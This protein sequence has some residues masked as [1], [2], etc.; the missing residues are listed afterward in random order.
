MVHA[1]QF[2]ALGQW[3]V[4]VHGKGI[5]PHVRAQVNQIIGV[6]INDIGKTFGNIRKTICEGGIEYPPVKD[7]GI[8]R[9]GE[10]AID[11]VVLRLKQFRLSLDFR[12][13]LK[14]TIRVFLLDQG[15]RIRL[16]HRKVLIFFF[17]LRYANFLLVIERL[18]LY[19]RN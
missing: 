14:E 18:L 9:L 16:K 3:V 5:F 2:N 8:R 13:F 7:L 11:C 1:E 19:Q 6:L 12:I 4:S 17:L 10:P 15:I